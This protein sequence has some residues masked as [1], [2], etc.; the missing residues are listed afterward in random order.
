VVTHRAG[1]AARADQVVWLDSGRVR[2]VGRHG[3][4]WRD[5]DYRRLFGDAS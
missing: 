5:R 1:T 3:T 2:A 4:L